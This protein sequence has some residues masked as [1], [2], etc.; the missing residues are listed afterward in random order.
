MI[1]SPMF[2]TILPDGGKDEAK[3]IAVC[4]DDGMIQWIESD[5]VEVVEIDGHKSSELIQL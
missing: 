5:E 2:G 4:A 3:M 1:S